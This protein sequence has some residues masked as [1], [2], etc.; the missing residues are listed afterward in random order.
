M[1]DGK[2]P[3]PAQGGGGARPPEPR[4]AGAIHEAVAAFRRDL[5]GLLGTHRGRWVAYRGGRRIGFGDSK[6]LLLQYCY[7]A[8]HRDEELFVAKV[9][10]ELPARA[11][12][13]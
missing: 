10:P 4:G 5:P 3:G 1:P 13:L 8:G 9:Q 6:T 11:G 7:A 2:A 12:W